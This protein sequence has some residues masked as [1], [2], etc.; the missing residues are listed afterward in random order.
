[1]NNAAAVQEA[2]KLIRRRHCIQSRPAKLVDN[3]SESVLHVLRLLDLVIGPFPVKAQHRNSVLVDN[4]RVDLAIAIVVCN[5]LAPAREAQD[6]APEFPV[7]AFESFSVATH[8]VI[9]FDVG[10][11]WE[12]RNPTT[13][14]A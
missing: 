2:V 6:R 10:H 12:R 8:S 5:H 3:L 13:S 1:M 9:P 4:A 11:E 7:I 14:A